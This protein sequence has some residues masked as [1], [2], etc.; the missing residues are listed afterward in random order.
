MS[1]MGNSPWKKKRVRGAPAAPLA[2][3]QKEGGLWKGIG[4]TEVDAVYRLSVHALFICIFYASPHS[5]M[6]EAESV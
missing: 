1:N 2:P 4:K 3:E 6:D 5:L